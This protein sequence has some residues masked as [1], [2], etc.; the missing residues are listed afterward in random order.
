MHDTGNSFE[1]VSRLLDGVR[2]EPNRQWTQQHSDDAHG[3]RR[4][5]IVYAETLLS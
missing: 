1:H 5:S 3:P 2:A 4:P